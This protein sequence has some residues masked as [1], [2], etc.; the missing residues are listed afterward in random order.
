[1]PYIR[2]SIT[3]PRRGEEAHLEEVVRKLSALSASQDG[4]IESYVLRPH[5]D[6]GEIV[7]IAVYADELTAERA[8]NSQ[9]FLALRSEQH[10][11][12]EPGHIERA[13]FSI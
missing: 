8:A 3:K 5:D 9:S 1:M 6:S 7:R 12:S 4:C 13:F 11:I 10:L 2:L